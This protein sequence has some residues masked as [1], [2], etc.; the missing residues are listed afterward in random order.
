MENVKLMWE[1]GFSYTD[2]RN[3]ISRLNIVKFVSLFRT[4][5]SLVGEQN[6]I[7]AIQVNLVKLLIVKFKSH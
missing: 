6:F 1:D 5:E 7:K 4:L 2:K 3:R